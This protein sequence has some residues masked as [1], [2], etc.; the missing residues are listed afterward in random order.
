[1]LQRRWAV[2]PIFILL[3][4]ALVWAADTTGSVQGVVLDP[5]GASVPS[6]ELIL[7]NQATQVTQTQKSGDD[8]RY[9]FNI[10]VPGTY[11]LKT[12]AAGFRP[13]ISTGIIVEVN[14]TSRADISLQVG[15]VSETVEVVA[16]VSRID[17]VSAQVS[18]SVQ[19]QYL[20]DLPVSSRNSLA[21]AELA[22]GVEVSG[23]SQVQNIE[24]TY[25]GVN[26]GRRG[27][28]SFYL[29][30]SDNTGSFRNSALQFP[31]PEAV[32][33]VNVSTSNTS[34]EFGKQ[35]GGMFNVITKSGTNQLHGSGFYFFRNKALNANSW[36]RNKSGSAK[37]DNPLK[38]GGGTVGGPIRKDKTFFFASYQIYNDSANGFQNTVR[39]PTAAMAGGDFSQFTRPLYDPDTG[40]PIPGNII[41]QRLLDP[42]AKNLMS[43]IPTVAN[44][45]DRYVWSFTDPTRNNELL[46]KIDHTFNDAH[47]LQFSYFRTWGHFDQSATAA[48]A[49]V[50]AFGPQVNENRQDTT[51]ARHTWIASPSMVV[52]SRF[53]MA[54]LSA[55]RGNAAIGKN[56]A[57]FG[58]KWPD[59]QEGARKYLPRLVINDGFN[60]HQGWLSLF[61]QSNYRFGSTVNWTRGSHNLKFGGEF[62]RDTVRQLNDQDSTAF[63]FDGRSASTPT[64]GKPTGVNVFGYSYAD[65]IMGRAATFSTVGILDYDIHN[66]N[67]FFFVE[68]QWKVT[69]R[70]TLTPGLRYELYT[71]ASESNGRTSAFMFG[72][73][74]DQYP[75][76]PLH[77]AFNGDQ[78][79]PNGFFEQDR[80][81]FAPRLG[82]AYDAAGNGKTVIRGGAG[83]YYA[84]NSAQTKLWTAEGVPWRPSASGGETRSLVDPWGTSRTTVYANPPT[85]FTTDVSN[86]KYPPRL[87]NSAGFDSDFRTPYS[88]QWNLTVARQLNEAVSVEA[89]YVAN[90][91]YKLLQELP[92]NLPMWADNASLSNLESR[93]PIAGFG[94]TG[95][96]YSRARSWYDALQVT[97]DVRLKRGLVI[98]SSY[99]FG[100]SLE[101]TGDDPTSNSN[102][103]TANPQNWDGERAEV[104][105]RHVFKT[106]YIYDLPL[107]RDANHW[108]GRILGGWQASGN[109]VIRSGTPFD[110]TLGEDW[111]FDS[112]GGDRPN[113]VGPISYTG[114]TTDEKMARYFAPSSFA[115]PT[116][117]NT[118][119]TLGRNALR[120]PGNWNTDFSML[121]RFTIA[122]GK[123][124]H[125]RAE[126]YNI[127]NHPNIYN[128]NA[129]MRS[130]DYGKI[131]TKSGNRTMQM[132]LRFVF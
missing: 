30:G 45:G 81:N 31:N 101:Y 77:L 128:P 21:F 83:V 85:P 80:N 104:G 99:V 103:Q 16:N 1:M 76:A 132:A 121:K 67:N 56:L 82:F 11:T 35:P 110:V 93:R 57:D 47:S 88:L 127:F 92:R 74:S 12:S 33:E 41:P 32:Q 72:H 125:F 15:Q 64:G 123:Q 89:G 70:L 44:Y 34:A 106:F 52:Q 50:A 94:N 37:P 63:T 109:V 58:A 20:A 129:N 91:A 28:N 53:A 108:A 69:Q 42:V 73:K 100:K 98:R 131:L 24:G 90:R 79:V 13:T 118:F 65:F 126:A 17:T 111:N 102:I 96:V 23:G 84:Y 86:F 116:T 39:F 61:D 97:G 78:G 122:E 36:S 115:A 68:D 22:P 2:V 14:K 71:P 124:V 107:W 38:Q 59:S 120:G 19:R 105:A 113:L 10:V 60:T 46:G 25:A 43:L 7:V 130:S 117:R 3:S 4:F 95:V 8:G 27:K 75:N 49:N 18:M 114:G 62:Q 5:S 40:A 119:G 51:S 6:V 54:K 55:D 29:D 48:G 66:W 9:V 112:A 26:G 87:D